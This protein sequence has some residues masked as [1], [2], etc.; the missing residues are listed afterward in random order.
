MIISIETITPPRG[1]PRARSTAGTSAPAPTAPGGGARGG[2]APGAI[3]RLAGGAAHARDAWPAIPLDA[4]ADTYATLHM[5]TQIVGK[6]RLALAP[7][8]NHWWQVA[9]YVT[10]RGLT[11]SPMPYHGGEM[12]ADFDFTEHTLSLRTSAGD[13]RSLW[14]LPRTVAD[15]Y[16]EYMDALR[17]LG[18]RAPIWPHPVEVVD[19]IPFA[20][21]T[22]HASYDPDAAHRFWLALLHADRL[23]AQFRGRFVG[24]SSP[25][26]FW[27]GS[28]DLACTRFNGERAPVHPGGVP[29]LADRVTREAY[30]HAC[31]SAGWWPGS[32]D[33]PVRE[34]AFYA[35]AYPEPAG[36]ADAR[37]W[38]HGA[39]YDDA[40]H[41]WILPYDAARRAP[42]PDAAVLEFFQSTYEIAANLGGWNRR[43]LERT[44][45]LHAAS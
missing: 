1:V 24:K 23:L 8:Q 35:Y 2:G 17:A 42:D 27:W 31:I 13:S 28:F 25:V 37:V 18:V 26:H 4:W 12:Q 41:E 43:E 34:P 44:P 16:H 5:W 30:S 3:S 38:P 20:T 21:D 6:T 33:G 32:A 11:T 36:C 40:L 45:D 9:L 10:A 19:P 7:M 15:F 22:T 39:R 14:L 29:H